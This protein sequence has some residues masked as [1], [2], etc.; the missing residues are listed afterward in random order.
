MKAYF[1]FFIIACT[2]SVASAN[3]Q[4]CTDKAVARAKEASVEFLGFEKDAELVNYGMLENK[5]TY[6][7]DSKS[8]RYCITYYVMEETKECKQARAGYCL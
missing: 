4:H 1:L 7:I 3:D 2:V 5:E 6:K 8:G